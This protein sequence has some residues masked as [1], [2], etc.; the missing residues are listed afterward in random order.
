M[1]R[2]EAIAN[3]IHEGIKAD[4]QHLVEQERHR[5]ALLLIYAG[6]DTMAFIS[7]PDAQE[8]VKGTD[9]IGWADHFL[10]LDGRVTGEEL[11]AARCALL[12]TYST[13]SRRTRS[14]TGVRQIGYFAGALGPIVRADPAIDPQFVMVSVEGLSFAFFKA[15]DRSLIEV[16]GDP[17]RRPVAERR[18][19]ACVHQMDQRYRLRRD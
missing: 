7:M 16:F 9:F 8:D 6:M 11:Y 17:L 19:K 14:G 18:L 10:D 3:V 2:R 15:I 4:I 5:A 13:E 12:H 1:L